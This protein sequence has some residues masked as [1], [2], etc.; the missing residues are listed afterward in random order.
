M[1]LSDLKPGL[2]KQTKTTASSRTFCSELDALINEV[3]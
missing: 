1:Q 2:M 3:Q